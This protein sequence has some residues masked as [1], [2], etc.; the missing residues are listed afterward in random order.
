[1]QVR[2]PSVK[3][4]FGST[5]GG[6][7]STSPLPLHSKY[8]II[9]YAFPLSPRLQYHVPLRFTQGGLRQREC[10]ETQLTLSY[11]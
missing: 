4:I 8:T 9:A 3:H 7:T 11:L 1:M 2:G 6:Q 5:L 10:P